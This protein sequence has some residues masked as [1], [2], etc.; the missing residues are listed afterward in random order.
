[1]TTI[2]IEVPDTIT[3]P[4][5]RNSVH[6]SL[7]VDPTKFPMNALQYLWMY[8]LTQSLNDVRSDPKDKDGNL[9][10]SAQK[11]EKCQEKLEALYAGT[12]RMRGEAVAA[13]VYE[14]EAIR[15]AKRHVIATF[16]KNGL[17]KDIPKGTDNRMMYALN[18]HLVSQGKPETTEADY[19][20]MFFETKTGKAIRERAIK[21]VDERR[22]LMADMDDLI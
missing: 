18:R 3:L 1:M 21:T 15:E 5:G 9:L 2:T 7:I 8:G 13:D 6:G 19:L 10:T 14:A 12:I 4:I 17:M 22:S 20:A 11:V 16:S